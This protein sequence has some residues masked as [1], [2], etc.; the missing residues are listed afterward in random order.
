MEE[1]GN[2]K[3]KTGLIVLCVVLCLALVGG[4]AF[5]FLLPGIQYNSAMKKAEDYLNNKKYER[6]IAEYQKAKAFKVSNNEADEQI[7]SAYLAWAKSQIKEEEFE[8]AIESCEQAL[9][10]KEKDKKAKKLL[11]EAQVGL[12]RVCWE[13]GKT[14]KAEKYLESALKND[15][16]NEGAQDLS[17]EMY[18]AAVVQPGSNSGNSGNSG[19]GGNSGNSGNS[20]NGGVNPNEKVTLKMWCTATESDSI[21]HAY[22]TAIDEMK[23]L[24]PNVTLEWECFE[25]QSYKYKIKAAVAANY[26]PDIFYTWPCAFLGD[27][28]YQNK[29]YCL[30]DVYVNYK[31]ELPEVMLQPSTY[32]GKHYGIPMNFNTVAFFAN[33]DVLNSVGYYEV[34]ATF[35]ELLACCA[36]LKEYG[37]TPFG[38]AMGETWCVSE[39]LES[40]FIK[41][42]GADALNDVFW[43]RATWKNQ[44]MKAVVD[45]LQTMI[46]LGYFSNSYSYN[47]EIKYDFMDDRYAFYVNGTW[48]CA[49]FAY[50]YD[51]TYAVAEFPVINSEKSRSGEFIGGPSDALA[52]SASSKQPEFAA[53]YAF[54]LAREICRVAYPDGCGLP[55]WDI[56]FDDTYVNYLTVQAKELTKKATGFT[57]YGDTS[58]TAD[59]ANIYLNY[60]VYVGA[61]YID[62]DGFIQGLYKDIR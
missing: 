15:P 22:V 21:R 53:N 60:V 62:G 13:D 30:D 26:L 44:D 23:K 16:D 24:Y 5:V 34:P 3:G 45:T 9:E 58:M 55:A 37:I 14:S 41:D 35:E 28:V 61:C 10:I 1:K 38:C 56:A 4:G 11:A 49:E 17:M 50:D 27:F 32:N 6:A 42:M 52:I 46:N 19:N 18:G 51:T 43:G 12:A 25:S 33:M 7:F 8:E 40:M 36:K 2:K 57:V 31:N 39:Y 47:D 29:V 59:E 54:A 20:G 48:N